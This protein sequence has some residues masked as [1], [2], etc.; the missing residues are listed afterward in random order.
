MALKK[1]TLSDVTK[2]H[3]RI[4]GF[5]VA[6]AILAYVLSI[7]VNKPE[8]VYFA[9][10]INYVLY[11]ISVELKKEGYVEAIKEGK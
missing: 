9:P 8:L 2:R 4:V 6:S 11:A 10:V 1:I 5:L 7:L 3:L